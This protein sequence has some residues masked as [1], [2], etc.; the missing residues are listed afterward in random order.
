MIS[1][2]INAACWVQGARVESGALLSLPEAH[3]QSLLDT[4]RAQLVDDADS[5]R[6]GR[7]PGRAAAS[8]DD[9][10]AARRRPVRTMSILDVGAGTALVRVQKPVLY[11][12]GRR[13]SRH[14]QHGKL[15]CLPMRDALRLVERGDAKLPAEVTLRELREAMLRAHVAPAGAAEPA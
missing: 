7:A 13:L 12:R 4:G 10:R 6:P 14:G 5:Q 11:L 9:L 2:R 3:A 15:V 1:V 8:C